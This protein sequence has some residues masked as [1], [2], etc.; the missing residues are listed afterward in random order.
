MEN[1]TPQAAKKRKVEEESVPA[2][3]QNLLVKRLSDKARLPTRG[4][5]FAAGYD[6]YRSVFWFLSCT[7]NRDVVLSKKSFL[8][9]ARPWLT[10]RS[11]LPFPLA[12]MAASP[13]E[14]VLVRTFSKA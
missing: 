13:H 11:R 5:A 12:R 10:P 14:A 2:P 4:S 1:D 6:L 9:M 8:L 3:L 7:S